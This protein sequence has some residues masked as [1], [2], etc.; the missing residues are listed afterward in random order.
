MTDTRYNG[1]TNYE[2]W[3]IALWLDN[4]AGS[5]EYWRERAQS[6]YDD[7]EAHDGL[8]REEIAA[9]E[10]ADALRAEIEEGNPVQDASLYSDLLNAAISSANFYEIAAHWVE[11]VEKD[12][13]VVK[14]A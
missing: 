3:N 14:D 11:E 1:W 8:T 9:L 4:D 6:A 10:L 12:E 2:T 13:P 7:A 5:Y